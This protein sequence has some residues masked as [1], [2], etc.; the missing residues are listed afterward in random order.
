M[1]ENHYNNKSV[2]LLFS[3]TP[4]PIP[5]S[6]NVPKEENILPINGEFIKIKTHPPLQ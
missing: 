1:Q 4:V 2:L 6:E 5:S 3:L